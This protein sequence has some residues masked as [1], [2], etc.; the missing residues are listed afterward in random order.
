[1]SQT[2][3]DFLTI[4]EAAKA[5]KLSQSSIYD[6]CQKRLLALLQTAVPD[7]LRDR[8]RTLEIERFVPR[9]EIG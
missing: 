4:A 3:N 2:D 6:A 7:A 9:N 1:M 5:T 8:K